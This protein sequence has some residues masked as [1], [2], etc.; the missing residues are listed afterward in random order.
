MGTNRHVTAFS[1]R[2]SNWIGDRC[3]NGQ[4]AW[5]YQISRY[6]PGLSWQIYRFE[7][8]VPASRLG[9]AQVYEH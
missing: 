4:Q 2:V 1:L 7:Y 3:L 5:N 8:L 6:V 9:S